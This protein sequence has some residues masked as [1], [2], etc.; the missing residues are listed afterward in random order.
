M[1]AYFVQLIFLQHTSIQKYIGRTENRV[2]PVEFSSTFMVRSENRRSVTNS[3]VQRTGLY[4]RSLVLYSKRRISSHCKHRCTVTCLCVNVTSI[5][6]FSLNFPPFSFSS[7]FAAT[8]TFASA[9]TL[10]AVEISAQVEL[11]RFCSTICTNIEST[12]C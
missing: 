6:A 2:F 3:V 4:A 12:N 5:E 10:E 7:T 1:Y 11:C 8:S 9:A